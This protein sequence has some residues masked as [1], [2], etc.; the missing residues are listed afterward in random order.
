[1]KQTVLA[2]MLAAGIAGA[3]AAPVSRERAATTA[4]DF[5]RTFAGQTVAVKNVLSVKDSY[6]VV[7]LK[8]Q[9]WVIV[10]ADDN[11][12]PI[13]GKSDTGY[14]DPSTMN[15]DAA[16]FMGEVS[17]TSDSKLPPDVRSL[18]CGTTWPTA[19]PRVPTTAPSLPLSR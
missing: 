13:I 1:M 2:I 5:A 11:T 16:F 18:I 6:Y 15:S 3:S 10:A 12:E 4:T 17:K 14:L 7:N 9:G 19:M 8:P